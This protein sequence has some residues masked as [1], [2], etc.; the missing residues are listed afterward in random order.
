MDFTLVLNDKCN[1]SCEYCCV[2][3]SLNQGNEISDKDVRDFFDWQL[4]LYPI[5]EEHTVEFFGGEPTLSWNRIK[6]IISYL[7]KHYPTYTIKYRIYT[8][9]IFNNKVRDDKET[10]SRFDDIICSIDGDFE[11][12]KLRTTSKKLYNKSISNYQNLLSTGSAG[13]AFVIH[14]ETAVEDVYSFFESMGTRYYHFEIATLWNDNIDNQIPL[15]FLFDICK[16]ITNKILINNC[17]GLDSLNLFSIPRELLSPKNFF[18]NPKRK[19]CLDGMRSLS[20]RGNIYFCR[21]LAV[22]EDHL[23][24]QSETNNSNMIF[25][26]NS[27]KPYNIKNLQLDKISNSYNT[28]ARYYDSITSCPVKSFEFEHL[29]KAIPPWIEDEDFQDIILAPIFEIMMMTFSGYE[30]ELFKNIDFLKD[31]TNKVNLY[32]E[33]LEVYEKY[34]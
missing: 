33:V 7:D 31:Y 16:F 14:P 9:C 12:N 3:D 26:E 30:K 8:N 24:K 17:K 32:K 25:R 21:D 34:L 15:K 19:S 6:S 18:R 23:I 29:V 2:L 10:W 22:S 13:I 11:T 27:F 20:P 4:P 1:L 5:E 28:Q